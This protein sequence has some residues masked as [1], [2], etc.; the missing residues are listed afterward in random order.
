MTS[1]WKRRKIYFAV[2]PATVVV[3]MGRTFEREYFN[4]KVLNNN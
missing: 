2:L 1:M 4:E 3:Q